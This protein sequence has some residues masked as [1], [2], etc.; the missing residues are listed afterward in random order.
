MKKVAIYP[1]HP[2]PSLPTWVLLFLILLP[3]GLVPYQSVSTL[4]HFQ[5][6]QIWTSDI[7]S[8]SGGSGRERGSHV[9][10]PSENSLPLLSPSPLT[11]M[12]AITSTSQMKIK[13]SGWVHTATIPQEL[14]RCELLRSMGIWT[15]WS[16][17]Q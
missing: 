8:V 12:M 11:Q 14:L 4:T 15:F 16:T 10:I 5:P 9:C 1:P 17:P 13:F 2:P 7:C 3:L 6:F